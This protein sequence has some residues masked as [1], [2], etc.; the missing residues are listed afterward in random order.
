LTGYLFPD[1]YEVEN[2]KLVIDP[3]AVTFWEYW[4]SVT[5]PSLF[6]CIRCEFVHADMEPCA[7][8]PVRDGD[9]SVDEGIVSAVRVF[10]N[11]L[12]SSADVSV[13]GVSNGAIPCVALEKDSDAGDVP[14]V[15]PLPEKI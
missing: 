11:W 8:L 12:N 10:G 3:L 6:P 4:I 2:A 1:R 9:F 13:P 5:E 14:T 7:E 15:R